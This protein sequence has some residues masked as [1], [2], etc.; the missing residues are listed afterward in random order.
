MG[1][2]ISVELPSTQARDEMLSFLH[3]QDWEGLAKSLSGNFR[4]EGTVLFPVPGPD[5]AYAPREEDGVDPS[6]LL[7]YNG[8][9]IPHSAWSVIAWIATQHAKPGHAPY[10]WYDHEK[11]ECE[12]TDDPLL[13]SGNFMVDEDG[14][15]IPRK[16]KK[17]GLK[18][19]VLSFIIDK[20]NQALLNEQKLSSRLPPDWF[21]HQTSQG[22]GSG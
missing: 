9:L 3:A 4:E 17:A 1:Y 2:S 15:F 18:G 7:G 11:I 19:M 16:A 5:L 22:E 10:F 13:R 14:V 6:R 21:I 12:I 8:S 20:S